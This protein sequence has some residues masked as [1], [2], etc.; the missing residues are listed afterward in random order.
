MPLILHIISGLNVGGAEMMLHRL[1]TS[2]SNGRFNH[3]VIALSAVGGMW[4]RFE[5]IGIRVEAVEIKKRPLSDFLKLIIII[6][7]YQ[8]DI[9][10]T[11]LVHANLLG[12]IAARIAG[13][14]RILWGIRSAEENFSGFSSARLASYC[15]A[16][17]SRWIPR[18]IVCA[19]EASRSNC[20][21]MGYNDNRIVVIPNGFDCMYLKPLP[22]ERLEIRK[23]LGFNSAVIVVGFLG[24]FHPDK[25]PRNFVLAAEIIAREYPNVVFL[26]IGRHIEPA[27]EQLKSYLNAT[28]Y[29]HRF[30]LL[31]ER[32]DTRICLAAIDI[33]CLS[34]LSEGFPNVVGEAMAM[35]IPCVVTNTGDAAVLVADTGVVVPK[36]NPVALSN[37]VK[38]I[39]NLSIGERQTLGKKARSRIEND[40]SL[41]LTRQRFE[42]VYLNLLRK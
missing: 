41:A 27:N 7:K 42:A 18:I 36:S 35:G 15:C 25:D 31:G 33:F 4:Q 39:I 6:K 2:S 14:N 40:F 23:A 24:R 38:N 20:V 5:S 16:I 34:S 8:P 30:V 12:S 10:Q 1:I 28:G 11:W 19:A 32:S 9:V 17:L 22:C 13:V 21:A 37:G 29:A 3:V 26:M